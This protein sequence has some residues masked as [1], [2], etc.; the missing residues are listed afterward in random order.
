MIVHIF[1]DTL[2]TQFD[3]YY[4]LPCNLRLW[5]WFW[6]F[7]IICDCDDISLIYCQGHMGRTE[8]NVFSAVV[9]AR[10]TQ[11]VSSLYNLQTL[12]YLQLFLYLL[13]NNVHN[14]I[15]VVPTSTGG[16]LQ[17][18]Y[19]LG[20]WEIFKAKWTFWTSWDWAGPTSA[21]AG[22]WLNLSFLKIC[23]L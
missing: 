8:D 9:V 13:S 20:I 5:I 1:W 7:H 10:V 18:V 6:I 2:Y 23:L 4:H 22:I 14:K 21:Q 15:D 3:N 19:N 16:S 12:Q 17:D 11:C